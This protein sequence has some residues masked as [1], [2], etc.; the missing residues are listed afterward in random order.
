[1]DEEMPIFLPKKKAATGGASNK[2]ETLAKSPKPF[3]D[4]IS[5]IVEPSTA[6]NKELD[7]QPDAH[8]IYMALF[9]SLDDTELFKDAPKPKGYQLAKRVVMKTVADLK[10]W[11]LLQI[12]YDK[13][14]KLVT[15]LRLEFV[16]V[17]LGPEGMNE[18]HIQ[19]TAILPDGWAY[20][21][22]HASVTR[23]DIAV[24]LPGVTMDDFVVQPQQAMT[25]STWKSK[26][27]LE[28]V[29]IGK[30]KGNQTRIYSRSQKRLAKKQA[31]D[32]APEVRVERKLINLKEMKLLD[33]PAMTNPFSS[34]AL[35]D[36][37]PGPPPLLNEKK[38]WQWSLFRDSVQVRGLTAALA[39]LPSALRTR[40]RKHLIAHAKSY[41]DPEAIW[42]G[43]KLMLKELKIAQLH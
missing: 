22:Q 21:V 17:D 26:G 13:T 38:H 35:I 8:A 3:I 18:L 15:R 24:D 43:W 32:G 16:P 5:L 39:L 9:Q 41:W 37:L 27:A 36:N 14:E 7:N 6:P 29:Y 10:K 12:A 11:P 1:M 19:L 31:W 25:V 42:A 30:S 34:I 33:L 4:K 28:S 20:M 23:I 2:T 40:F